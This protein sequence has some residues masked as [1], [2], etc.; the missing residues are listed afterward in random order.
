MYDKLLFPP[1]PKES[2][3]YV[4]ILLNPFI[5]RQMHFYQDLYSS[6]NAMLIMQPNLHKPRLRNGAPFIEMD[7]RPPLGPE[8]EIDEPFPSTIGSL[9]DFPDE[10]YLS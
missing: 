10:R 6:Q 1:N 3:H 2:M 9:K 5:R 7:D 4:A 8:L